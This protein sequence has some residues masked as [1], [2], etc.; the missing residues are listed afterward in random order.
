MVLDI[1]SMST[2][3][4]NDVAKDCF[5]DLYSHNDDEN[6]INQTTEELMSNLNRYLSELKTRTDWDEDS[7]EEVYHE[8]I[9]DARE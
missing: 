2:E 1:E 4:L 8:I 9:E 3:E 7:Y 6:G 5:R